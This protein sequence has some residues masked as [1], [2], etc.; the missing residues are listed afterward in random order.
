MSKSQARVVVPNP[1]WARVEEVEKQTDETME[2][3]MD[4]K[5]ELERIKRSQR[6]VDKFS[7]TKPKRSRKRKKD[8]WIEK[9]QWLRTEPCELSQATKLQTTSGAWKRTFTDHSD[10]FGESHFK[11]AFWKLVETAGGDLRVYLV[12]EL[13]H[14]MKQLS[15][16]AKRSSSD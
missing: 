3:I 9:I 7:L 11:E 14:P 4:E 5:E 12:P 10:T 8:V 15:T 16:L 1:K 13:M 6:H 2:S